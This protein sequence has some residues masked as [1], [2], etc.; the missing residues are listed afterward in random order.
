MLC[1]VHFNSVPAIQASFGD[2]FLLASQQIVEEGWA[3]QSCVEYTT[4][5]RSPQHQHYFTHH[6]NFIILWHEP[7]HSKLI[8][9]GSCLKIRILQVVLG[10]CEATLNPGSLQQCICLGRSEPNGALSALAA[11][12]Q[13]LLQHINVWLFCGA[14]TA[15]TVFYVF[16]SSICIFCIALVSDCAVSFAGFY[17][18]LYS[19]YCCFFTA[20]SDIQDRSFKLGPEQGSKQQIMP[21]FT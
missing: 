15:S 1:T 18:T 11:S 14:E 16:F 21:S 17:I 12:T 20:V 13:P 19:L 3:A 2:A 10:N 5:H 6:L 7:Q 9:R 8:C 4:L